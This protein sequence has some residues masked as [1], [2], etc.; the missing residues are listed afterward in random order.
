MTAVDDLAE[1]D[2]MIAR[3]RAAQVRFE[4]NG[5]QDLYDRAALAAGWAIMEPTRNRHLAELAVEAKA[6]IMSE[7]E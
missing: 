1:V 4:A 7:V 2:A 6:Q 5:S 3:A